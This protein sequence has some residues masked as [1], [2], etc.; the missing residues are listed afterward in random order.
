MGNG[1][2]QRLSNAWLGQEE[3]DAP[4][5]MA[6]VPAALMPGKTGDP[7]LAGQ[8]GQASLLS[9][10]QTM[11]QLQVIAYDLAQSLKQLLARPDAPLHYPTLLGV[12]GALAGYSAQAGVCQMA[13]RHGI[14][15]AQA[16]HLQQ[17]AD[18]RDYSY[19]GLVDHLLLEDH[20]SL[21]SILLTAARRLGMSVEKKPN[22]GEL[23]TYVSSTLG[24]SSFG[25]MRLPPQWQPEAAVDR[26][27]LRFWAEASA[28]LHKA[29]L[30]PLHWPLVFALVAYQYMHEGSDQVPAEIA[31]QVVMESALPASRDAQG[32]L[33]QAG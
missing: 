18:G 7:A 30:N 1:F 2:W 16:L 26:R 4:V 13:R 24:T 8:A 5:L 27:P 19:S 20:P 14:E 11:I 32:L 6:P 3:R 15:P 33:A 22:I 17:L 12:A 10:E 29:Q 25:V 23:Q 21:W 31:L 9:N 28:R